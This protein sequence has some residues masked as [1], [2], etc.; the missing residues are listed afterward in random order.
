MKCSLKFQMFGA[1][2]AVAMSLQAGCSPSDKAT[3]PTAKPVAS[4]DGKA[5]LS[6]KDVLFGKKIG[7]R[8]ENEYSKK[9]SLK[10]TDKRNHD[11]DLVVVVLDVPAHADVEIALEKDGQPGCVLTGQGGVSEPLVAWTL[12]KVPLVATEAQLFP[13]GSKNLYVLAQMREGRFGLLVFPL[14][15]VAGAFEIKGIKGF[16]SVPVAVQ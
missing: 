10:L 11:S 14:P 9:L 12:A 6:V 16:T 13:A 4:D 8:E 3:T 5:T 1:I 15:T 7:I 2:I